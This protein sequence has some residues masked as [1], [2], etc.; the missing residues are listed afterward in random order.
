M[1]LRQLGAGEGNQ[2]TLARGQIRAAV[3]DRSTKPQRQMLHSFKES[4]LSRRDLH[5]RVAA[6]WQRIADIFGNIAAK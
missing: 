5:L 2:L 1:R 4:R 6:V 3:I